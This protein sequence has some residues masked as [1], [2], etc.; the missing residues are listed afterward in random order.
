MG[1]TRIL[2]ADLIQGLETSPN[3][4]KN[5]GEKN[6][7]GFSTYNDGGS[8][9]RPVDGVGG[10]PTFGLAVTI[11]T[12]NPLSGDA[13]F[14]FSKPAS[15]CRGQGFSYAFSVNRASRAKVLKIE[16]DYI[17]AS[18]TF[19]AGTSTADSDLIVYI[20]DVDENQLIE[21]STFKLYSNAS[22]IADRFSGYFQTSATSTNYRLIFHVATT[23]ASAWSL[24]IDNVI[25]SPSKYVY[26]TPITDWVSYTLQTQNITLGNGTLVGKYRRVGDSVEVQL[27]LRWGSTTSFSGSPSFRIPSEFNTDSSKIAATDVAIGYGWAIDVSTQVRYVI[28]CF[29]SPNNNNFVVPQPNGV[30]S[31]ITQSVPFVWA[32]GDYLDLN[33]TVPIQ[34]W[35]SSVKMSDGYE[36]REIVT[37]YRATVGGTL[38]NN[39]VT[40]IDFN[41]KDFNTTS[42]VVGAGNGHNT[43]WQNTWRYIAPV[44]GYYRVSANATIIF[45]ANTQCNASLILSING[46]EVFRG[47]RSRYA[48]PSSEERG[49]SISGTLYLKAGDAVSIGLYQ[50]SGGNRSLEVGG[51]NEQNFVSIERISSPQAIAMGEVLAGH[52]KNA[53]GQVIPHNT[54]TT[55]TSW[56]TVTDTHAIFNPSTGVL[57]VNRSGFIDLSAIVSF[58]P[59]STGDRSILFVFNNTT[60]IGIVDIRAVSGSITTGVSTSISCYPVK[61][62]DT[63]IVRTF[64]TSGG[65]LAI[66]S[67]RTIL[68]WRIY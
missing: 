18:G 49:V 23:N 67:D 30:T 5:L 37:T 44:S 48:P 57:T 65:N 4:V 7:Y 56:T 3:F 68:S 32:V 14:L 27:S 36:G 21:P 13:S 19:N 52:A 15:N 9:S 35:S 24:R 33:F 45:P 2:E 54:A 34:G 29:I 59:N 12:T 39:T 11:S 10:S 16:F 64:Q 62:G 41:S 47:I 51:N 1:K 55:L 63:F 61:S 6:T 58:S 31:P 22:N 26:G 17:V 20:Y 60:E 40:F 38:V 25:V 8:N 28:T 42:S 66:F 43:N 50:S 53:S 46:N